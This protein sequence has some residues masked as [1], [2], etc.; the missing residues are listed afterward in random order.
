[1]NELSLAPD[2]NGLLAR[3]EAIHPLI[4]AHAADNEAQR[5]VDPETIDAM[6]KIGVFRTGVPRRFGGVWLGHP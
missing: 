1:M 5:H 4:R 2:I 3:I 6:T